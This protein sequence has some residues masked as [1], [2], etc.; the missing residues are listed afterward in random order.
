MNGFMQNHNPLQ[1]ISSGHK[2]VWVGQ[3]ILSTIDVI[4]FVPAF[5]KVL[6]LTFNGQIGLYCSILLASSFLG[7]SFKLLVMFS[8][9]SHGLEMESLIVLLN[10]IIR[11]SQ[12][13]DS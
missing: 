12:L 4:Q 7:D 13:H 5:V 3:I 2:A 6:K 8:P 1:N 11:T 10:F 9:Q